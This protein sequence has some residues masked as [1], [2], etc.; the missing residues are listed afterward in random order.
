MEAH[1]DSVVVPL[2]STLAEAVRIRKA[3]GSVVVFGRYAK[4]AQ[5]L[6]DQPE[7][8]ENSLE[9]LTYQDSR[10]RESGTNIGAALDLVS[11]DEI[12]SEKTKLVVIVTDG[13]D[14][15]ER[16]DK[17]RLI[18]F[19]SIMRAQQ[20]RSAGVRIVVISLAPD[21][22]SNCE[23]RPTLSFCICIFP[24]SLFIRIIFSHVV[25]MPRTPET[26][27]FGACRKIVLSSCFQ[28]RCNLFRTYHLLLL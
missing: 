4:L 9:I 8:I 6:T 21:T 23:G 14:S 28:S 26:S 22:C 2:A 16:D 13:R 1:I 17:G 27:C 15:P 7:K 11:F 18:P 24:R 10:L 3:R 25:S 5:P 20:L 12:S 19:H